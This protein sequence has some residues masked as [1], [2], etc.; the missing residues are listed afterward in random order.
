MW[1]NEPNRSSMLETYMHAGRWRAT[2]V[3]AL[4]VIIAA[5]A[6][7]VARAE[8]DMAASRPAA[9]AK[10]VRPGGGLT[11]EAEVVGGD[12]DPT[13]A[14]GLVTRSGLPASAAFPPPVRALATDPVH[15]SISKLRVGNAWQITL[16]WTGGSAPYTL[17]ASNDPSFQSGVV[18][19][20]KAYGGSSFTYTGAT[21]PKF[22]AVVDASVVSP[23]TEAIGYDPEPAPTTPTANVTSTWWGEEVQLAASYLD[24]IPEGNVGFF[25]DLPARGEATD[26]GS[27]YASWV[28]F[29]VPD[30]ARGFCPLVLS[31][32]RSSPIAGCP[33]FVSLVPPGVGPFTAIRSVAWAPSNGH[34]W[35]AASGVVQ[36]NDVFLRTPAVVASPITSF[37]A[38]YISRV[39]TAGELLIVDGVSG[40]A[41]VYTVPAGGGAPAVYAA[42]K[43]AGLTRDIWPVGIAVDPDGSACY[44]ADRNAGK[45]VKIP[46]GAGA[47][48]GIKDGWGNRTFSF[49][50][51][52][53]IDVN[54]GHQVIVANNADGYTWWLT[55]QSSASPAHYLGTGVHSIDIDDDSS[56]AAYTRYLWTNAAAFAEAFNLN[57][58]GGAPRYHGA[59]V[60]G[61]TDGTLSI[62]PPTTIR[63]RV[64]SFQRVVL[65]NSAQSA[66]YPSSLQVADRIIGLLADGW[67][68]VPIRLRVVDPP[69]LAPYAPAGGWNPSG[70]VPPYEGNDNHGMTDYGLAASPDATTWT[71]TLVITPISDT[72]PITY[73][74]KVPARYSGNNFQVEITKC[75]PDGTVLPERVAGL[76][77]VVTAWKRVFVERDRMFRKGGLLYRSYQAANGCGHEG[78]PPCTTCGGAGQPACCGTGSQ[79]ACDQIEAYDWQNAAVGDSIV[80]FDETNTAESGGETRT[81]TA[82]GAGTI[83]G[84][85]LVTLSTTLSRDYAASPRDDTATPPVPTF[86]DATVGCHSAGFG[87]V[88]GCDAATNQINGAS[89]C[90]F[91]VD[92]RDIEQ[93]YG[94]AFVEHIGLRSGMGAVPFLPR[95]WFAVAG[96]SGRA[97]FSQ[98]WFRNFISAGGSPPAQALP[99][100]YFHAIGSSEASSL[101]LSVAEYDYTYVLV[102]EIEHHFSGD[103]KFRAVQEVTEHEL[104]HQFSLNACTDLVDCADPTS[105]THLNHDYRAW[106]RFSTTGCPNPNPC[107]MDPQGG[108]PADGVNRFCIEDLYA[109]DPNAPCAA[110]SADDTALRSRS[111]PT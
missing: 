54:A 31:H 93:P 29:L 89:T 24:P 32:G 64:A 77:G 91:D 20:A 43:D 100:N 98:T 17:V 3:I 108:I 111:D 97:S 11:E 49:P 53:G 66:A 78:E 61:R 72:E 110:A 105:P 84:T 48:T 56:D 82:I 51:P 102:G 42:T 58:V 26:G 52:C 109:G 28:R 81:I 96:L 101:G 63:S 45:V 71:P 92:M 46:R 18:T 95:S 103:A 50:D 6:Q 80:V 94:D 57:P 88:S 10:A 74:L 62:E 1:R 37:A 99:H 69:D 34:V 44:I 67:A 39:T 33:G 68:G 19:L 38:P 106:W 9:S 83:A 75:R 107:L 2:A 15:Q 55:G 73:Y 47:G 59:I 14:T 27:P 13:R 25:F 21:V 85:S 30:D 76:S 22:Y 79:P 23:V 65:N 16:S 5:A 60:W 90:F 36:Q 7:G 104:G 8:A 86:C 35:V 4:A 40:V 12:R 41:S 87:V 70:A